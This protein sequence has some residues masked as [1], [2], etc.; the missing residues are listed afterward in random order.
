MG[1]RVRTQVGDRI[2]AELLEHF[3]KLLR[4]LPVNVDRPLKHGNLRRYVF[5]A[6]STVEGRNSCASPGGLQPPP[7]PPQKYADHYKNK[8]SIYKWRYVYTNY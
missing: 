6:L 2:E 7:G 1:Q 3:P 5:A 4:L 8:M